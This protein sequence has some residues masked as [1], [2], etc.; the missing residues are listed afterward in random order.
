MDINIEP[1]RYVVAVSGG[2]D[3]MVLLDLL[4]GQP[5][6]ELV[7]AH[8]DHGMRVDSAQDRQLVQLVARRYEIPFVFVEGK[9]GSDASEATARSARYDFLRSA[10]HKHGAQAIITAH[11]QDDVI[12]TTIINLLRGTNRKGLSSLKSTD[13]VVRPL[14]NLTKGKLIE[15]ARQ[16]NLDWH[17]DSTNAGDTYLRNYVRHQL[18]ARLSVESR[19]KFLDII[20]QAS[21]NNRELDNLLGEMLINPRELNRALLINLPHAAGRELLA[22]WL[23]QAGVREFDSTTLE[24]LLVAAKVARAGSRL[25]VIQNY[26]VRVGKH[27]LALEAPER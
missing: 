15:Y 19:G 22:A 10:Q 18:V 5:G 14:L 17:E 20:N 9:L 2:V 1:G 16:Q 6:V 21:I 3:S 24:R 11:H 13:T 8:Y 23:R 4:R 25:D 7:V 12:E 26:T 27:K